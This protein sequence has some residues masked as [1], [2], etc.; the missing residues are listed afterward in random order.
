MA[1]DLETGLD[2]VIGICALLI[3]VE[4]VRRTPDELRRLKEKPYNTIGSWILA[5]VVLWVAGAIS[6]FDRWLM[7]VFGN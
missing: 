6:G 3:V 5:L 4:V 1:S 2:I 7:R